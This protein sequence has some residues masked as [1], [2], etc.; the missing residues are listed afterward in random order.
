MIKV[1]F[2]CHGNTCRSTMAE[3]IF[4]YMVK[5][6]KLEKEFII[7]SSGT[8]VMD[9]GRN[10]SYG[11][12]KRLEEAG[13]PL[14]SHKSRQMYNWDYFDYDYLIGMD[15]GNVRMMERIC[16]ADTDKKIYRL[17][18]F[19]DLKRDIEDPKYTGDYNRT[20][21]DI[22]LGLKGFFKFLEDNREIV[23]EE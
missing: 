7:K 1:L 21:E 20:Y 15:L 18:D 4:T 2:V 12:A 13:I 22:I 19:T 10:P 14:I 9:A 16:G 6:K 5:E 23:V 17:L 8:N 3:S 11:T